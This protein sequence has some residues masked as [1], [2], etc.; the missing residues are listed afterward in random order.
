MTPSSSGSFA[1]LSAA[2][3][4]ARARRKVCVVDAGS[5]RNRFAEASHGLFGLDGS[6]PAP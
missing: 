5:P 3:Q 6:A 4:I 2:L 1:G